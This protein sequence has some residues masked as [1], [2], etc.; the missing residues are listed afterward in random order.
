MTETSS[1]ANYISSLVLNYNL[2]SEKDNLM[3]FSF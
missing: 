2:Y 3:Q 1:I